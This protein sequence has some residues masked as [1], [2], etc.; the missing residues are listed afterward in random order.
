LTSEVLAEPVEKELQRSFIDYS[1]SVI[2]S[3]AIPDIRD[4]LKPV[5]RRI[6]YAMREMS[7]YHNKPFKKSAR[8]TGECLGKYHPHGDTA[9]YDALVRMA[10]N[11]SM[12]YPLVEGQGNF[13]SIDRDPPAAMRYTEARL[14]RISSEMLC[15]LDKET[16][17]WKPNFD[18]S[19]KEPQILPAK[20]PNLL[21]NG[22]GG[23]AVGMVTNMPP[24]NLNEI[25]DGIRLMIDNPESS[26]QQII[27]VI[28]GPD[29]PT[30]GIIWGKKGIVDAYSSGKGLIRIRAKTQTEKKGERKRIVV[31]ELPYQVNKASLLEHIAELVKKKHLTGISDLRDESDRRGL[32]I[33]IS[34]KRDANEQI[35]LN[36]LF[37]HSFLQST[38]GVI[39]LALVSGEPRLF[40][41]KAMLNQYIKHRIEIITKATSFDLKKSEERLHVVEGLI[42][43]NE[44]LDRVIELI[45]K[46]ENAQV[47]REGLMKVFDLSS[48]Q[49][50]EILGLRLQ[51]LTSLEIEKIRDEKKELN[52]KILEFKRILSDESEVKEI[53][54]GDL[55][56][57]KEKF[58]DKRRTEIVEIDEDQIDL[59]VEELIPDIEVICTIT[60]GGYVK[61]IP[62]SIYRVQRRG[63]KGLLGMKRK[64]EDWVKEQFMALNRDW[65]M[66]FTK[67]G[68][69]YWLKCYQIPKG[70][71]H[72][73]GR[74]I[75]NLLPKLGTD[76][77]TAMMPTRK[78]DLDKYLIF[79]TKKGIVKKTPLSSFANVRVN[80]IRA[81][82]LKDDEVV[83]VCYSKGNEDIM[84][85]SSNGQATYFNETELR[86][87][88]R[89]THGVKG[90]K[91]NKSD[92]VVSM[93][94]GKDM[95]VL[96][97]T[98]NGYGKR[99]PIQK[100]RKTH[101]GSK[102]VRT[103][104]VNERNGKVIA[105][106]GVKPK[107][108]VILATLRGMVVRIPVKGIRLKGRSTQGVRLMKLKEGDKVI[109]VTH[110]RG[111]K[112]IDL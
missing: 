29:F 27:E 106:K 50:S 93:V 16:V 65:I 56:D 87:L 17:G 86:P 88:S 59:R 103:I 69:V 84:L 72:A 91:L 63:G 5:Q 14:A 24:H 44:N 109:S 18:N 35:V 67:R 36:Q 41:L 112:E 42:K 31:T 99:T 48:V 4:G 49:A 85:A 60:N 15:D 11:F 108:E 57:L 7:L 20:L 104:V 78:F 3:R 80:G 101:R 39:N 30:G 9:I 26:I 92:R 52:Q 37:K 51:Q 8:I 95:D 66:F 90:M 107:D 13:G 23:I 12:R 79:A 81:I 19:L 54:K 100:Y 58:G 53:I 38:F 105:I 2:T 73:R 1:M 96:T 98:E 28:K 74:P 6:L 83:S 32:R 22:S 10:Q 46:S 75:I 76:Q 21:V 77:I 68:K 47:A 111:K 61:R 110:L 45:R 43:A 62:L 71:R 33:V 64:A 82:R 94:I 55:L 34:L 25:V 97:I 40:S 89:A 102:G 70:I